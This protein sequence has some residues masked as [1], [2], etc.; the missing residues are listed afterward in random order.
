LRASMELLKDIA[1]EQITN[2]ASVAFGLGYF[3]MA[4]NGVFL[5][6]NAK[7]DST[8]HGLSVR[9]TPTADLRSAVNSSTVDVR[10]MAEIGTVINSLTDVTSGELNSRI[11][12]G[13]AV[14]LTG[15]KIKIVGDNI[16]NGISLTN[17]TTQEVT[18]IASNSIAVND[19]SKV[20]F[21]VPATLASGDYKLSVTT[22]YSTAAQMLKEPRTFTFDYILNV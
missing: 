15:S 5:G 3:N 6:D 18:T 17:Q 21:I 16:A 7:W 13:G 8:K 2:G 11:S 12:K 22:Q 19:P 4:V 9:V 1:K 20:T 10:G 14:N